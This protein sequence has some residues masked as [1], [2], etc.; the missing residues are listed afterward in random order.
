MG[1]LVRYELK[2]ILMK[3][4]M[5]V[6]FFI[7]FALNA[8]F[9]GISGSLGNTYVEG[10]FYETHLERNRINRANGLEMSGRKMDDDLLTEMKE[11][12]LK[13]DRSTAAYKWTDIYK[14]E[15]RKYDDIENKFKMWGL[16]SSI[17]DE[18]VS[19]EFVGTTIGERLY[20]AREI[21]QQQGYKNLFLTE[22]EIAFWEE[23]DSD[24]ET[25]FAYQYASAYD[26]LMNMQGIYMICM[27]V[28]FFV[29]ITM[30]TVFAE[31]H[32]KKT[33]QLILCTRHGRK[34]EYFAKIIAGSLVSF[35]VTFLFLIVAIAGKIYSYG[36]EGFDTA[37]QVVFDY[38]YPYEIS[39]GEVCII[40][41]VLLL[42]AS[43]LTAVF[44]MLLAELLH[45]SVGAMAVI[46]GLLFASR[47][48]VFPTSWRVISQAWNYMPLNIVKVDGGFVDLRTVGLFGMQLTSWQFAP[49]LYM[50]L[51]VVLIV[52]GIRLYQSYQVSGR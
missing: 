38:W 47:L 16:K 26:S 40:S 37:F 41:S 48:V 11:V 45:N 25:P 42:L 32:V 27:M 39:V 7:L 21:T 19:E 30:V 33:D 5:L 52:G 31:E 50:L 14:N 28:S 23:K 20:L 49:I 44:A 17:L 10:E 6:T 9:V 15:V 24:V 13:V 4:S 51:I 8:V 2:K 36:W 46:V 29:A 18:S 1:Q 43:V 12:F 34:K 22:E 3:K 35:G